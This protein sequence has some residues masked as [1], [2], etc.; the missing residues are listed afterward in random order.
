MSAI[1]Q[2]EECGPVLGPEN[3]RSWPL[4]GFWNFPGPEKF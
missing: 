2:L 1:A 3:S 4:F